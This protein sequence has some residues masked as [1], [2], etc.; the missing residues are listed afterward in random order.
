MYKIPMT[1]PECQRQVLP[2]D[3]RLGRCPFCETKICIPR[4]Y[5]R[6][7]AM[8]SLIVATLVLAETFPVF[9]I[10]PASFPFFML[11]LLIVF[12]AFVVTLFLLTKALLF[13]SPP[14]VERPHTNGSF[15]VLRLHD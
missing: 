11:W 6:P 3:I 14:V 7:A 8:L 2:V 15:T 5:F 9:V 13:V 1:C 4:T 12:V 10:S